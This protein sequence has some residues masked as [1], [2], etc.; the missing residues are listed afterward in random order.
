MIIMIG[1]WTQ[2]LRPSIY[3]RA[4]M[5]DTPARITAPEELFSLSTKP[6]G[7]IVFNYIRQIKHRPYSMPSTSIAY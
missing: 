2:A 1:H 7:A 4:I 6:D 5:E 3:E